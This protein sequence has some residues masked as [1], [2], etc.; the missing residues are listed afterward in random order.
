[1]LQ[2][3]A[4]TL[5]FHSEHV[6]S[7]FTPRTHRPLAVRIESRRSDEAAADLTRR[8]HALVSVPD[9]SLGK[10]CAVG[11]EPGDGLL[12]A[13]ASPRGEQAYAVAR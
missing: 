2:R 7:S 6:P 11:V 1:D 3:A 8:G 12:R 10:V 4:E 9:W 5:A 13:A